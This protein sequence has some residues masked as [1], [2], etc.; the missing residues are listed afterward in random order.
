V[1]IDGQHVSVIIFPVRGR[2]FFP[3]NARGMLQVIQTIE[4]VVKSGDAFRAFDG[5][6]DLGGPELQDLSHRDPISTWAFDSY[7]RYYQHYCTLAQKFRCSKNR[8]SA[9][10]LIGSINKDWHPLG[11]SYSRPPAENCNEDT[12]MNQCSVNTWADTSQYRRSIGARVFLTSNLSLADLD[13]RI[14]LDVSHPEAEVLPLLGAID[15]N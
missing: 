13:G 2:E 9:L 10:N 7:S 4:A 12:N 5:L 8:Y 1:L 11:F 3:A 14:L 6:G 15:Q